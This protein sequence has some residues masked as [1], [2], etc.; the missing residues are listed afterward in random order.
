LKKILGDE[1]FTLCH[2]VVLCVIASVPIFTRAI[3]DP[4]TKLKGY[5]VV[6]WHVYQDPSQVAL[7]TITAA[8][9]LPMV[10]DTLLDVMN[11]LY[12]RFFSAGGGEDKAD[13]KA[14]TLVKTTRLNVY[15]RVVFILGACTMSITAL[16]MD[17]NDVVPSYVR[18]ACAT[19]VGFVAVYTS[20]M[21]CL[22]RCTKTWT[23]LRTNIAV[24]LIG[25]GAVCKN[26]RYVIV[27]PVLKTSVYNSGNTIFLTGFSWMSAFVLVS[28][29][30]YVVEWHAKR[31][32]GGTQGRDSLQ[33]QLGRLD[34]FYVN[35]V[36]GG[37][38]VALLVNC[39]GRTVQ[40]KN[41]G[42]WIIWAMATAWMVTAGR[43]SHVQAMR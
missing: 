21:C 17:P 14:D 4:S 22:Q 32:S 15:E 12:G 1:R 31:R 20:I 8:I 38:M 43:R 16:T 6:K 28:F 24:A 11:M 42:S 27:D 2:G 18:G 9:C 5:Q 19:D 30:S 13:G 7:Y 34:D 39:L 23:P 36:P 35:I 33:E 26:Y 41:R 3:L 29:A 37:H 40:P 10:V 25:I